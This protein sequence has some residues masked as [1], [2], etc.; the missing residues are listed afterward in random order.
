[1]SKS[2]TFLQ[3]EVIRWA[4]A[5]RIYAHSTP[6]AQ[7]LKAF[8]EMGELASATGKA[9][10]EKAKDAV[11]DVMVCLINYCELTGLDMTDCLAAAWDE[12]KDR[13]GFMSPA[14]F[15]VKEQ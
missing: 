9:D 11:G 13:K 14:G 10:L 2:F 4:D 1:M 3:N 8:E 6:S 5:R 12:I 7:L 15:F